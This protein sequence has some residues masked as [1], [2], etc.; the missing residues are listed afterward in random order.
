MRRGQFTFP[1]PPARGALA[2]VRGAPA[3]V[4]GFAARRV[5]CGG[6]VSPSYA[7][8]FLGVL[9]AL[10]GAGTA[11]RVYD[12]MI[13]MACAS[14]IPC[15]GFVDV[16]TPAARRLLVKHTAAHGMELKSLRLCKNWGF[17]DRGGAPPALPYRE[18]AGPE[19]VLDVIEACRDAETLWAAPDREM[20]LHYLRDPR[21][22]KIVVVE[23]GGRVTAAAMVLLSEVTSQAGVERVTM[24]DCV[25]MPEPEAPRVRALFQAA[26]AAFAGQSS[27]R[28]IGA[29][30]LGTVDEGVLKAAGLR[31]AAAVYEPFVYQN[32]QSV[33]TT[34]TATNQEMV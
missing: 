26:G 19:E 9:P 34:A 15:V 1:G 2:R 18:A 24:V 32:K 28:V 33:F 27:A 13:A 25:W 6:E 8:A 17:L 14:G 29:P 21:G 31:P 11:T 3:A 10:R 22:R 30:N 7:T 16:K 5:R 4:V 12:P 23:E 20:L